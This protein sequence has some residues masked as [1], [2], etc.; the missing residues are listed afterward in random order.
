[1]KNTCGGKGVSLLAVVVFFLV[2]ASSGQVGAEEFGGAIPLWEPEW[3]PVL[4]L[5]GAVMY[6]PIDNPS[7]MT[8]ADITGDRLPELIVGGDYIHVL[9]VRDGELHQRYLTVIVGIDRRVRPGGETLGVRT[10]AAGDLDGDGQTDLVV[11]TQAGELWVLLNHAQWGFQWQD[12]SPYPVLANHI[13][14]CDHDGDG[15]LDLFVSGHAEVRLLRGDGTGRLGEPERVLGSEGRLWAMAAGAHAGTPG[16]FIL[17]DQGLWFLPLG[18]LEAVQVLEQGG[19]SL[20]VGDFTG[21]GQVDVAVGERSS[22]RVYPALADGLGEAQV[23]SVDHD[24]TWT[25]APDVNGDGWPDL[26]VGKYSPGGFSVYYNLAGQGFTGPYWYGVQVPAMRGLPAATSI[27]ATGDLNSDGIDDLVVAASLGHIAFFL[28]QAT[29]RSIQAIPGSFLLGSEDET[30]NLLS[31]TVEGGIATLIN[32]GYGTFRTEPLVGPSGERRMPYIAK[33]GDVTSDG[34]EELVVFEFAEDS[35]R[36]LGPDQTWHSERSNARITVWNLERKEVLWSEPLGEEIRPLLLL[37]DQTGDGVLDV[38][39]GVGETVIVVSHGADGLPQRAEIAWGGPV[40][41]LVVLADGTVA[42]L[43]VEEEVAVLL[44]AGSEVVETGITLEIA[45]LDL[46][47]ADLDTDGDEDL[48]VIGWGAWEEELVVA[49]AVLW[50][51]GEGGFTPELFPILA[52][53]AT[54]LPFPYGGLVAADLDGDGSPELAVMRLPDKAENPGGVVVIPWTEAGPGEVSF[55][56]GCVGTRLLALD[57]DG[58]GRA[59]LLSVQAGIPAQLCVTF[60][61]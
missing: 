45:P 4:M 1:M 11:A 14:L 2:L 34:E 13:C 3:S 19:W 30:L 17:T 61:R 25:L 8:V 35:V 5:P 55:L 58:D 43:R 26:V 48:V 29:G 7:A 37:S 50:A 32:S 10:M 52:W 27:A 36:V 51:D 42:G 9:S 44:L 49:V 46:I 57:V 15:Q 38:V 60:W 6:P 33:F 16:L 23:L 54:A 47:V 22:V 31:S 20:A 53:P 41:P 56:P 24:V 21:T 28:P 59:E 12:G 39:T 18:E 40:G